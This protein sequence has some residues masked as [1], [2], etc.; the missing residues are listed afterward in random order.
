MRVS[1]LKYNQLMKI[2]AKKT[3]LFWEKHLVNSTEKNTHMHILTSVT[4]KDKQV[5]SKETNN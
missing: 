4:H 2:V 1:N 5:T 3:A